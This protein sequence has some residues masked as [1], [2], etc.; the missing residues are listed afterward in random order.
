[1][2]IQDQAKK[3]EKQKKSKPAEARRIQTI[4]YKKKSTGVE[5]DDGDGDAQKKVVSKRTL[6]ED[7]VSLAEAGKIN[8]HKTLLAAY[9]KKDT[10]SEQSSMLWVSKKGTAAFKL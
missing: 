1:M 9:R 8:S 3:K 6:P 5:K 2:D 4:T 7:S 10:A